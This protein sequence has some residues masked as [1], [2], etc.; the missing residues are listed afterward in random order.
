MKS[1]YYD[2]YWVR[3]HNDLKIWMNY[4]IKIIFSCLYEI[5]TYLLFIH[6]FMR[7]LKGWYKWA[8]KLLLYTRPYTIIY[9]RKNGNWKV[10]YSKII[11]SS[12]LNKYIWDK[13]LFILNWIKIKTGPEINIHI[14]GIWKKKCETIVQALFTDKGNS[15]NKFSKKY[16]FILIS[17]QRILIKI[18]N[19]IFE[20]S[21]NCST[22]WTNLLR[23][24]IYKHLF[25]YHSIYSVNFF[26]KLWIKNKKTL[27]FSKF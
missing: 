23:Y 26:N 18:S 15:I 5:F 22:N 6:I 9:I 8:L 1:K 13:Y 24:T 3:W 16:Q 20:F 17:Y 4:Q 2:E 10:T 19:V 12:I 7:N 11:Q 14:Y 21:K 27:N 25:L